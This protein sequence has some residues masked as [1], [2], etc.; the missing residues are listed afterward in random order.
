MDILQATGG[1]PSLIYMNYLF[2]LSIVKHIIT[3]FFSVNSNTFRKFH[4]ELVSFIL[5]KQERNLSPKYRIYVY[6][7]LSSLMRFHGAHVSGD[8]FK[9]KLRTFSE[10]TYP[11]FGYVMTFNSEPPDERLFDITHF[12]KYEYGKF[13]VLNLRLPVM[14]INTPYPGDYRSKK[15]IKAQILKDTIS[16]KTKKN[17]K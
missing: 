15:E 9:G 7:N 5:N 11:P 6:Y 8:I 10:I 1:N 14:E 16:R 17:K 4:P 3:M 2:P 12:A 13:V